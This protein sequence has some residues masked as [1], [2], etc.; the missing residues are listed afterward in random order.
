MHFTAYWIVVPDVE[1]VLG[2]FVIEG[3]SRYLYLPGLLNFIAQGGARSFRSLNV[4]Q[5]ANDRR[6]K[7]EQILLV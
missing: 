2:P 4:N 3:L 5:T 1:V 6:E 7:A